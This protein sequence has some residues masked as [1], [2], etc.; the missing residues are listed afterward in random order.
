[1][2][3]PLEGIKVVE[4]ST[5]AAAPAA[6]RILSDYG[7][8][9]I[10]IE[11]ARGDPI[12]LTGPF[13]NLPGGDGCNPMFTVMNSG[14]RCISVDIK[15]EEGHKIVMDLLAQA[16]VFI[17]NNREEA[18]MRS[19]LDYDTLSEK[20][21]R[22]VFAHFSG[23]GVKGQDRNIPGFDASAFWLRTGPMAD[24]QEEGAFPMNPSYAFGDLA[25]SSMLTTGIMMALHN[26]EKTGRG[27]RVGTSLFGSGIWCNSISVMAAQEPFNKNLRP[28][29]MAPVHQFWQY[30]RCKDGV[31][32]GI[33]CKEYFRDYLRYA[34]V[35]G[36]P[37]VKNDPIFADAVALAGSKQLSDCVEH[38]NAIFAEKTSEEWAKFLTEADIPFEL[39]R[40]TSAV[41]ADE[42]AFANG[43]V[44]KLDYPD[45]HSVVMPCYPLEFGDCE[46][47][48]YTAGGAIGSDTDA[49][50]ADLGRSP[51]EIAKL[52]ENKTV[53]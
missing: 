1:M 38:M 50:L 37:E 20:F 31:W 4:L 47:R 26:R 34:D 13:M 33:F 24:W 5:I 17:T 46:K 23:F 49:V 22:L 51:E 8:E 6:A 21:P 39:A 2:N 44:E 27:T 12:R 9:V 25:T 42:Q 28:E 16:D 19:G 14:K 41:S 45:G 18:L 36:V 3:L 35:F 32:L 11:T 40:S 43:Y 15:T 30:Y 10:K 52:H 7:A 29:P 53:K 48:A